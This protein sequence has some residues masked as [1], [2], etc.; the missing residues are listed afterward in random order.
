MG[1]EDSQPD[2]GYLPK[3]KARVLGGDDG[4]NS[5]DDW[6]VRGGY[7]QTDFPKADA[8]YSSDDENQITFKI[9]S[10]K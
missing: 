9:K 4:V 7:T 2:G 6:F 1:S 5:S 8:I 3:G 10:K